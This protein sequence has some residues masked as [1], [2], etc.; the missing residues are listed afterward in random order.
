MGQKSNKIAQGRE[1]VTLGVFHQM[2]APVHHQTI[3]KHRQQ[4]STIYERLGSEARRYTHAKA[5]NSA[6]EYGF[7]RAC[8]NVGAEGTD[9]DT[10][11]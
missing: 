9:V 10:Q 6:L 8:L 11:P 7:L 2:E 4:I 3:D 5:M 1:L